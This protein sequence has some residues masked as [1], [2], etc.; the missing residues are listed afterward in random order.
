MQM[1]IACSRISGIAHVGDGFT[2]LREVTF[3]QTFGISIKMRIVVDE[4]VVRA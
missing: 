3:G 2:L 1:V 4:P